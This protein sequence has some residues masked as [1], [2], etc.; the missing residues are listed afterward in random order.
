MA[1]DQIAQ[2][3]TML[4]ENPLIPD[5]ASLA[6]MRVGFD[7]M[8]GMF[9]RLEDVSSQ[10]TNVGGVDGEWFDLNDGDSDRVMLYLHGGGYLIGSVESHRALIERITKATGGRVLA[11]N[12]RLAPEF[13]FP[14]A[15]DDAMAAY[16]GLLAQGYHASRISIAGDSAGGGLAIA[17]LVA[18]RDAA[19]PTPGCSVPISPW[20]D[21]E[22]SGDSIETRAALDPMVQ[23]QV[24]MEMSGVYLDGADPKSP[25]ASPLN[26]DFRGLPP[27]L[28]QVGDAEVLLD[29]SVRLEDKMRAAGVDVTVEVWDEMVHVWHLFAPI[30]DKGQEAIDRLGAFVREKTG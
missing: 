28:I 3:R 10:I 7:S 9:P 17:L 26:A 2:I 14:A 1:N 8:G 25:M 13:P 24:L 18:L 27:V 29:D 30:L 20:T 12:Y 16:R 19:E 4:N 21:M 23:K 15:V 6:E 5:G 22:C 11:I